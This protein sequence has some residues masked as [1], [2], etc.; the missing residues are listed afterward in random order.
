MPENKATPTAQK[1]E[2]DRWARA[3]G[4]S[5]QQLLAIVQEVVKERLDLMEPADR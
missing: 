4:L 1:R 3:L 5:R 2:V